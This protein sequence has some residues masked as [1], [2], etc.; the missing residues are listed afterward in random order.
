MRF[1]CFTRPNRM[2]AGLLAGLLFAILVVP[3]HAQSADNSRLS[4]DVRQE[5]TLSGTVSSVL[6]T[7]APGMMFGSHLVLE[8]VSGKVDASL[9]RWGLEGKGALS[10]MPGQQVEVTGVMKTL[11]NNKEVFL[12]RTVKVNAKVYVIRTQHGVSVSPQ[13]RQRAAE[14]GESL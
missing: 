12:A 13:A 2:I 10:V 4:Y 6:R 8:T 11:I 9:G 7:P 5:V 3:L 14:K 1:S